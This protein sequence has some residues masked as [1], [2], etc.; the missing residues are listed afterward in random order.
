MHKYIMKYNSHEI[1]S[2][3][4]EHFKKSK[5]YTLMNMRGSKSVICGLLTC[6]SQFPWSDWWLVGIPG[7]TG[8]TTGGE[9]KQLNTMWM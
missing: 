8:E 1:T 4:N 9:A 7:D 2:C 3:K 5:I 6:V